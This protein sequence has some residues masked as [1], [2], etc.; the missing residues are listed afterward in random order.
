MNYIHKSIV[1]RRVTLSNIA[2]TSSYAS[3][4]LPYASYQ[5][6][7]MQF[8]MYENPAITLASEQ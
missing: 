3:A 5:T 2:S 1:K 7:D 8:Y 6:M 4:A